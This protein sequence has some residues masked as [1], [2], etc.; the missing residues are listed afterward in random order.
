MDILIVDEPVWEIVQLPPSS[1]SLE[2][3]GFSCQ[4]KPTV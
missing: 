4:S 3:E 1:S 2:K